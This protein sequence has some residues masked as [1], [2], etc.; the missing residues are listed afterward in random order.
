MLRHTYAT[1]LLEAGVDLLTISKLLGHASFVTTMIYLHCRRE[2]LNQRAHAVTCWCPAKDQ[3]SVALSG[4]KPP[5]HRS[6]GNSDGYYLV[7]ADSLRERYR[8]E[9]SR[10]FAACGLPE[11]CELGGKFDLPSQRRQL[12]SVRQELG[13]Q[14]VGRLHPATAERNSGA[15]QVVNY[16]TRYLTGGPISDR[17]IVSAS[18]DEVTFMAREG[19]RIG[20][21]RQQ[22]PITLTTKE[23]VRRWCLHI[24]PD[25]LTKTRYFGGWSNNRQRT[26]VARCRG[27]LA[28]LG[29][30]QCDPCSRQSLQSP[31]ESSPI[32]CASTAA[33]TAWNSST[34]RPS[35]R[36]KSCS[37]E[38]VTTCPSW[39]AS[40]LQE[41]HRRF[42]TEKYG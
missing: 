6:R 34:R 42:W 36:G 26:Y 35:L 32:W 11:S 17:R 10:N 8:K 22:V 3:A 9:R 12:G 2:H 41:S 24:Q 7:D 29:V 15:H 18:G 33:A 39:Y 1:G 27:L 19:K 20:G 13:I 30:G 40:L 38:R 25:Q 21:E 16:L 28:S 14:E 4:N 23:F 37:G 5:H 31:S